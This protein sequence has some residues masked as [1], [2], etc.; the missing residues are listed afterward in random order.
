MIGMLGCIALAALCVV[1]FILAGATP[2]V[3]GYLIAGAFCL[4]CAYICHLNRVPQ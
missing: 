3:Q 4:F 1:L 2:D